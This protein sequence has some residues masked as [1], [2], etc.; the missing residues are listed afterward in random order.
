M[1]HHIHTIE[2]SGSLEAT[3]GSLKVA[4]RGLPCVL[5]ALWN[6]RGTHHTPA[7][8]SFPKIHPVLG[9]QEQGLAVPPLPSPCIA[10]AWH[11]ERNT[12]TYA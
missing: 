11:M 7:A 2:L 5:T 3:E 6:T 9:P 1:D 8:D 10:Q 4:S 12:Q